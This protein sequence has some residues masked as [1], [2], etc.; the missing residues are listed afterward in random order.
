MAAPTP[1]QIL[2]PPIQQGNQGSPQG[3][4]KQ[5]TPAKKTASEWMEVALSVMEAAFASFLC[6]GCLLV[7]VLIGVSLFY[8]RLRP[9]LRHFAECLHNNWRASILLLFPMF[10][11]VWKRIE[12]RIQ[13]GFGVKLHPEVSSGSG[14]QIID[15]NDKQKAP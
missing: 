3:G 15:M 9:D 4:V 11:T 10:R 8:V 5:P 14:T 6:L 2:L 1:N 7:L 13:E 12:P